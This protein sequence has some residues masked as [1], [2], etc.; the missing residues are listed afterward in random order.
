MAQAAGEH[1]HHK[2]H[3]QKK[4]Q[5]RSTWNLDTTHRTLGR[6]IAF[7]VIVAGFVVGQVQ[8]NAT[9]FSISKEAVALLGI[10]TGV[11][12]LTA[13]WLPTAWKEHP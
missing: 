12:T 11:I 9:V 7:L 2:E 10:L 3:K 8:S 5:K 6:I 13:N 1:K 4:Q